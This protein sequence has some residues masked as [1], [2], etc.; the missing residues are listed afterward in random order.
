MGLPR[1]KLTIEYWRNENHVDLE[2]PSLPA[3]PHQMTFERS[4]INLLLQ[5]IELCRAMCD[6][7]DQ[8]ADIRAKRIKQETLIELSRV[9]SNEFIVVQLP[10]HVVEQFLDMIFVNLGRG[11]TPVART[12]LAGNEEP[13]MIENSWSHLYH[14][15]ALLKF[16]QSAVPTDP[17]FRDP[18]FPNNLLALLGAPDMN[19][20]EEVILIIERLL[21][22]F[23]E[24]FLYILPRLSYQISTY[25]QDFTRPFCVIPILKIFQARLQGT[26]TNAHMDFFWDSVVPLISSHHFN[27]FWNIYR[28]ICQ[29][30]MGKDSTVAS[31]LIL[32]LVKRWPENRSAKQVIAINLISFIFARLSNDDFF[33]VYREVLRVYEKCASSQVAKVAEASISVWQTPGAF[34]L[35]SNH[36]VLIFP[37]YLPI[38]SLTIRTHWSNRVQEAA[39]G[40]LKGM[41]TCDAF[42]YELSSQAREKEVLEPP[43]D[44][45]VV[46]GNIA[47]SAAMMYAEVN[48]VELMRSIRLVFRPVDQHDSFIERCGSQKVFVKG[49]FGNNEVK[50]RTRIC[51]GLPRLQ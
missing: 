14:I 13:V 1:A 33:K 43:S 34:E 40:L 27:S 31:K 18:K 3:L 48:L 23:P 45:V 41:Q 16:F 46:W 15:Y 19:E 4:E 5:K 25:M 36:A 38:L 9:F 24:V 44:H 39:M 20:R 47:R 30:I 35:L 42:A 12:L 2:L 22:S 26:V 28:E 50:R 37:F 8:Q 29:L 21:K 51:P 49:I 10:R 32:V 7:S 6:F 17:V 11:I